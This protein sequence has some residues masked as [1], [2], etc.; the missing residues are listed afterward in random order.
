M[1]T[2]T[3]AFGR[4]G[5]TTYFEI[6]RE[7]FCDRVHTTAQLSRDLHYLWKVPTIYERALPAT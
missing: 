6:D 5:T 1:A 4:R 7:A 3:V 2:T